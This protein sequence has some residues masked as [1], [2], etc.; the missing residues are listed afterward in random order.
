M[1]YYVP[2]TAHSLFQSGKEQTYDPRDTIRSIIREVI[3]YPHILLQ[4]MREVREREAHRRLMEGIGVTQ[5]R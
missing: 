1:T 5:L 3:V 2:Q 4:V